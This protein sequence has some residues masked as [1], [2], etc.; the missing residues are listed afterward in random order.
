MN[1]TKEKIQRDWNKIVADEKNGLQFV[2]ESLLPAVKE[3][4]EKRK[5][6]N[7]YIKKAAKL[8]NETTNAL[9]NAVFDIRK[10]FEA[11]GVDDI[12]TKDIGFQTEALKEGIF[13]LEIREN[14]PQNKV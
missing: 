12:W 2:P 13:I 1:E 9:Y 4:N 14:L 8:E 10:Y 3:W 7:E 11:N 6:L 5:E